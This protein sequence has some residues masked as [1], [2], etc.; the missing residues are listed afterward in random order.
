MCIHDFRNADVEACVVG[1]ACDGKEVRRP[2]AAEEDLKWA[3]LKHGQWWQERLFFHRCYGGSNV[4]Q[5]SGDEGE[6]DDTTYTRIIDKE[7][8][9]R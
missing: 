1:P 3:T 4:W 6:R 5:Q 9:P 7:W 8:Y 2:T